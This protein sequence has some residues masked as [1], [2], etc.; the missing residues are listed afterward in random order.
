MNANG[1]KSN[2]RETNEGVPKRRERRE[3]L[4]GRKGLVG[5]VDSRDQRDERDERDERD[6]GLLAG[7]LKSQNLRSFRM[8]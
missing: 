6:F 1:E 8:S 2:R 7:N 5:W 4:A 3:A